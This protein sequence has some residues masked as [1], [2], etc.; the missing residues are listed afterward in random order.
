MENSKKNKLGTNILFNL[1]YQ[2]LNL[3]IPFITTPY[4]SRILSPSSIGLH[5]YT[6]SLVSFFVLF[7]GLGTASY[8]LREISRSREDKLDYSKK[9][10][11]IE[12][13]TILTS[14][15]CILFWVGFALL[16]KEYTKA[17]LILVINIVA[18]LFDI[19]WL[20]GG[21]E[22]FKYTTAV[23]SIFKLLGV[24]SIF[25]FVKE[26]ADIY[27]YIFIQSGTLLL[28]N[29]SMWLFLPKNIKMVRVTR[30]EIW[31]HFKNTLV[32]FIPTIASS[33]YTVLD[34]TLIG[35]I[36]N[37]D[38]ENGYYEQA[39]KVISLLKTISIFSICVVMESRMAFL[40]K[41]GDKGIIHK[42]IGD[43]LDSLLFLSIA[44]TFGLV[45]IAKNFVPLFFGEGYD[46]TLYLLYLFSPIIFIICLSYTLS[47]LYYNPVGKRKQ[48]TKYLIIGANINLIA[49]T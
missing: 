25:L 41:I 36:T 23:N 29:I 49:R 15:I 43:C 27:K 19:S 28:G 3:I 26:D 40:Y 13:V 44:S 12:I 37:D 5:S 38:S 14:A 24:V 34:K 10:W 39:N 30:T 7:A 42:H 20:Y 2:V 32:Y 11:A 6:I 18:V 16:Y 21:L 45:S 17:M 48:T 33:I 31:Y 8:G 46:K 1:F 47:S 22:K 35:I 9:F 4:V